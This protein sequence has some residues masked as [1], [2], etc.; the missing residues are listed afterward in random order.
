VSKEELLTHWDG[1]I[2]PVRLP[3][4]VEQQLLGSHEESQNNKIIQAGRQFR[5]PLVQPRAH[6]RVSCEVTTGCSG[7][8]PAGFW[9][10]WV[11]KTSTKTVQPLW[12][13]CFTAWCPHGEKAFFRLCSLNLCCCRF[14]P[15]PLIVLRYAVVKILASSSF[16]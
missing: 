11:L 6:S 16:Y 4:L 13:T 14:C 3:S 1:G 9:K 2:H 12:T 10:P 7:L 5:R 15:L 8:H